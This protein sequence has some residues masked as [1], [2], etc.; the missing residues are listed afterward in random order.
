MGFITSF[1]WLFQLI[2]YFFHFFKEYKWRCILMDK[3][4]NKF[5]ILMISLGVFLFLLTSL[6]F[7]FSEQM[8]STAVSLL[9][10][11]VIFIMGGLLNKKRFFITT[12]IY[13][14]LVLLVSLLTMFLEKGISNLT[15]TLIITSA[16]ILLT[17]TTV[18]LE[19]KNKVKKV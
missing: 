15:Y 4:K 5:S 12:L 1:T 16:I 8:S 11:S 6:W 10:I 9:L 14:T 17:G 2:S 13:G 3:Y 7:L 19:E 18:Y